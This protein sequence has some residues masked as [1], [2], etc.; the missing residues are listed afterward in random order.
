MN[1][2]N[3]QPADSEQEKD[4]S[5]EGKEQHASVEEKED[6]PEIA[7]EKLVDEKEQSLEQLVALDNQKNI[8]TPTEEDVMPLDVSN[9]L[10]VDNAGLI[11]IHPFLKHFFKQAGLLS[12]DEK[13]LTDPFLA[14]H[15]LHFIATGREQDFEHTLLFEKYLV[16]LPFE[17]IVPRN[18]QIS[19]NLKSEVASLLE[20]VK[21]NWEPL[22][23]T[24]NQGLQETFLVRSGKLMNLSEHPRLVIERKTVDILLEKLPWSMS[25]VHFPWIDK[26]LYVEW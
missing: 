2:I 4:Q 24:S 17:E 8:E 26:L 16:G 11:L 21:E 13:S 14:V 7:V 3:Q 15:L 25:L 22:R 19:D 10:F 12:E 9:G 6:S 20:A 5:I 23:E 18:I 1:K